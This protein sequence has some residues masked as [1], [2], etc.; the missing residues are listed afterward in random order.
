MS[1]S[2]CSVGSKPVAKVTNR[3]PSGRRLATTSFRPIKL[4]Q[5]RLVVPQ[6]LHQLVEV[7]RV[8][9]R[10]QAERSLAVIGGASPRDE[11][12]L[13]LEVLEES[14]VVEVEHATSSRRTARSRRG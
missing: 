10:R 12:S 13:A 6:A 5:L 1:A 4:G 11:E 7:G 14:G 8:E 2:G 9:R 3:Y